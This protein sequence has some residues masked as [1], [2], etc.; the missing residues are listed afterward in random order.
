MGKIKYLKKTREYFSLVKL[1]GQYFS[2]VKLDGV[3]KKT[4]FSH[5]IESWARTYKPYSATGEGCLG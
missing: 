5:E 2:L 4:L 3:N 1:D